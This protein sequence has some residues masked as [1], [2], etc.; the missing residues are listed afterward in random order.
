MLAWVAGLLDG[1][2]AYIIEPQEGPTKKYVSICINFPTGEEDQWKR[3][4]SVVGN[5]MSVTGRGWEISGYAAVRGFLDT[6]WPYM[7]PSGRHQ[8]NEAIKFYKNARDNLK[9]EK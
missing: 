2:G 9:S 5:G 6:I 8:A 1:C 7:S 4:E 3:L